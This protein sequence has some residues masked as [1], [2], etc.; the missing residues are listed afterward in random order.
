VHLSSQVDEKGNFDEK[1]KAKVLTAQKG[2][3]HA[4]FA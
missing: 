1:E 4:R 2:I 3:K